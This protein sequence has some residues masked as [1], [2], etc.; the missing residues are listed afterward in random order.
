MIINV[1]AEY[2]FIANR[3]KLVDSREG[4]FVDLGGLY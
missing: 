2:I 4:V 3:I 1:S